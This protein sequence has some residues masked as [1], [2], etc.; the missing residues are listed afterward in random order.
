MQPD[1]EAHYQRGETP[2]DK[3]SASPPLVAWLH[4]HPGAMDGQIL[5]PGCGL[6]HDVRA[7]AAAEPHTKPIGFDLAATA[8]TA[9]Q[10]Q[11]A[12]GHE[13]YLL[14]DLFDL[15]ATLQK[16]CDWVW[17]HTCFC[18]IDPAHRDDYVRAVATALKPGGWL[19]GIFYLDPYRDDHQPGGGP[20]HGCTIEELRTRFAT[21][22]PF[23]ITAAEPP[24]ACY[25][26]RDGR[27]LLVTM[28]RTGSGTAIQSPEA[29]STTAPTS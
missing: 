16:T 29:T 17:E 4:A 3:G 22:G 25:P 11:P 24:A 13:Q 27:E 8:I 9:C 28:Q 26:E 23:R 18:A 19:L 6:G 21:K 14:G 20:P 15:P 12:V 2:W 1:W 5:V 7:I 10:R